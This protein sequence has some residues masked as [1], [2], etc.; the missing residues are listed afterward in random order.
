MVLATGV[1]AQPAPVSQAQADVRWFPIS[2]RFAPDGSWVVV[3]LCSSHNPLYCRLVRWEPNGQS[4]TPEGGTPVSGLWSLI[5]GQEPNKSYIWPSVSWNG[6]KLAYVVADCVNKPPQPAPPRPTGDAVPAPHPLQK[7]DCAFHEGQPA[8]SE[9]TVDLKQ[10]QQVM[11]IR[12]ASRPNWRPDDQAIVYW[13]PIAKVTLAS[14]RTGALPDV[15]EYDLSTQVETPKFNQSATYVSWRAV[16]SGPFYAPDGKTFA[17]CGYGFNIPSSFGLHRL[18][19]CIRVN[20][21]NIEEIRGLNPLSEATTFVW[22]MEDWQ[23]THWV[24][25]GDQVRL[26]DK[27]TLQVTEEFLNARLPNGQLTNLTPYGVSVSKGRDAVFV[28]RTLFNSQPIARR[29]YW[30]ADAREAPPAPHLSYYDAQTKEI[31]PIFWPNVDQLN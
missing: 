1:M 22:L 14:G 12:G 19:Q 18:I 26:V 24:T 17:I 5:G 28:N 11:A 13:R 4:Q 15:Y 31:R 27:K 3:N 20:T 8:T 30:I 9:S 6:R 10:G 25:N 21:Q 23:G 2:A 7:L 29:S 16:A